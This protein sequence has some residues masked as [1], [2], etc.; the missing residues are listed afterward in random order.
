MEVQK[1]QKLHIL[2]MPSGGIPMTTYAEA[3]T[4]VCRGYSVLPIRHRDKRPDAQA[5]RWAGSLNGDGSPTW[6]TYKTRAATPAELRLW[7]DMGPQHN[8]GL[9]TGYGGLVVIDFDTHDA[10]DAW[11]Q[12]CPHLGG[13]AAEIAAQTYRVRTARGMHV[14]VRALEPVDSFSVGHIDVK[15]RWGYVLAPP[16]VHPCGHVYT[17][18]PGPLM[19]AEHLADILPFTPPPPPMPAAPTR[20]RYDDPYTA[21]EQA[22]LGAPS[23]SIEAI[24]VRL[25][26]E[27]LVGISPI[28]TRQ[29]IRCP[30]HADNNPSLVIYPDGTWKCFGCGLFGDV[31]DFFAHQHQLSVREAIVELCAQ[32]GGL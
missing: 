10:Y 3:Q 21:A 7:F 29:M 1:L 18:I 15:G 27:D 20:S 24:K 17:A 32:I 16:S 31:V 4:W 5:L 2:H 30:F 22:T 12:L 9:V 8:L 6:N 13:A 11:L 25:R 14:Y 26:V 19:V 23:G 28:R